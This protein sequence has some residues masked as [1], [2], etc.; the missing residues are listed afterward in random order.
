LERG[1]GGLDW[2]VTVVTWRGWTGKVPNEIDLE[3]IWIYNIVVYKS[4][5]RITL[6]VRDVASVPGKQVVQ[7]DNRVTFIYQ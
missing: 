6:K 2:L 4:E 7:A 1:A 3:L 5:S